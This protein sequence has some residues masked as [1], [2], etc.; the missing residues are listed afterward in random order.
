MNLPGSILSYE[1][2]HLAAGTDYHKIL[3]V[4]WHCHLRRPIDGMFLSVRRSLVVAE[5]I[6]IW[7]H[8]SDLAVDMILLVDPNATFSNRSDFCLEAVK[9]NEVIRR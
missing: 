2:V 4:V 6:G 9:H 7:Q 8:C 1:N 5:D 3:R